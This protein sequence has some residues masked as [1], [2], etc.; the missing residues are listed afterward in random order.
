MADSLR[1]TGIEVIG[2]VPWS[3]HFCQFYETKEDLVDMLVPYFKA[4]LENNEFCM[5]VTSEPLNEQEAKEAMEKAL[6]DLHRYISRGQ[7]EILPYTVWYLKGGSF[8]SERVLSGWV[9][10]LNRAMDMGY[11]G[12]R[13][14]GNTFW[15][16]KGDWKDFTDYEAAVNG[17]IGNYKM[18]ALCTYSLDRCDA[19]GV[20]DVVRNHEFALIK[21]EGRWE[22]IE[23][24]EYK[25]AKEE[26]ARLASFP[27]M[28]PSPV[29]ELDLDGA[30]QYANP[31]AQKLFPGILGSGSRPTWFLDLGEIIAGFKAGLRASVFREVQAGHAWY[32]FA[33]Y[34]FPDRQ[35]I[36]IYGSDITEYRKQEEELR[37]LNRTLR[38][39]SNANQ[40]M[41]H[42]EGESDLL[43]EVC[44]IV[45][46]DCGHAMVWVGFAEED[47]GKT[48]RPVAQAG[49]EEGYLETLNLTWA[50]MERG[51]GPTG[52]AIRTGTPDICRNMLTD[53]RFQ[54]WREQ[55]IKRGYASSI[56]LPLRSDGRAF[57]ALTIYA[58]KPDPFSEDEVKLLAEL[59]DDLSYGITSIR[60]RLA[61]R[62]AE[63][64]LC[65]SEARWRQLAEAMPHLVWT[66]TPE[67]IC[68]FLGKQWFEYTSISEVQH[69]GLGW[70][71][72]L[73]PDDRDSMA[74]AWSRSV[75]SGDLYDVEFRVRRHD[76]A[77]RWFKTRAVPIRDES[78]RIF[79]WYGSSTDIHDLHEAQEDLETRVEERTAELSN[80]NEVLREEIEK[81]RQ[82]EKTQ[83]V[84]MSMLEQSNRE[85]EDFAF[86]ASHDLQEPLRKIRT[87]SDRLKIS[88]G[89]SLG[90]RG[91]DYLERMQRAAERM[92][93]LILALLAYS[94]VTTNPE[95]FALINLKDPIEE[96][97]K[98][99]TVLC[100]ETGGLVEVGELPSIEADRVQ[101]RQLFQNLI[102]NG[103]KYHGEHKPVVKIYSNSSSLDGF[104]EIRVEDNGI[105]FNESFLEKIFKPFQ[106]LHGKSAEYQGT[107]MGLAIC[108]RIVERHGGSITAKSESGK[109]AM[110]IVRMPE[111]QPRL[112]S[113]Q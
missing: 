104:W 103:L 38:A 41:I 12:L 33:I 8:E 16:E 35:C 13:L 24:S 64:A 31:S 2:K 32:Q 93:A 65:E 51:R 107:G 21:R 97:I 57:G 89:E 112:E 113:V 4:G 17:T 78:G 92:Q 43:N 101:M 27:E 26:L 85:L 95:P 59:A 91:C 42:A 106:R 63:A 111:R 58:R 50:D 7:I 61:R 46:E 77:Y 105:G 109:G 74:A 76:G 67:G 70:M 108:R 30:V 81:R 39:L 68:D 19:C 37:R 79:K 23:S 60:S 82:V 6:P 87:F 15:L 84:Y 83:R 99:L 54:P 55:A 1:E 47:E 48:V 94:R 72:Q 71:E 90:D 25:K 9:D 73:H 80:V 52:T 96:A 49:F 3:T 28:N 18:I 53:P 5:W 34:Y 75:Q 69:L 40:A 66:C 14:T 36:R 29:I 98:D 110:F 45:V 44:R 56:A 10:K 100:E 86:V 22:L 102:G 88:Y 62:Q 11:S 20:I